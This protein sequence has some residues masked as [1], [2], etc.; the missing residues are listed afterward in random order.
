MLT[1][2][3]EMFTSFKSDLQQLLSTKMDD[4]NNTMKSVAE[5]A[6]QRSSYASIASK[7]SS[8]FIVKP[9]NLDQ[10]VSTTKSDMLHNI[11]PVQTNINISSVKNARNGGIVISCNSGKESNK[12]KELASSKLGD[13]YDVIQLPSLNPRIKVVGISE[14]TDEAVLMDYIKIQNQ[15]CFT[16]DSVCKVINIFPLKKNKN[17]FQAIIQVDKITYGKVMS[18]GKLFVGM[19]IVLCLMRS[20]YEGVS[21]VAVFTT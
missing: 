11:D 1:Q 20:P 17:L 5:N 13:K 10:N 9:K 12:F 14:K 2:L 7:S 15:Q 8:S 3:D 4:I 16:E 18:S 6:P 21:N 19:I